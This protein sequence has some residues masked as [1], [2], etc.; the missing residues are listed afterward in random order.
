[1]VFSFVLLHAGAGV[2]VD[3]TRGIPV[4]PAFAV[5]RLP[6]TL[7][8]IQAGPGQ[9]VPDRVPSPLRVSSRAAQSIPRRTKVRIG[10]TS[11]SAATWPSEQ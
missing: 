10:R 9:A 5:I 1:M 3:V 7:T 2:M 6:A 4:F 11:N 8:R